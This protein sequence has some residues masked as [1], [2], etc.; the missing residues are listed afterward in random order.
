MEKRWSQDLS[1]LQ[2]LSPHCPVTLWMLM[3]SWAQFLEG[4]WSMES[5]NFISE[6]IHWRMYNL[7]T[8]LWG[9]GNRKW[10]GSCWR[11]S[12][13]GAWPW[14]LDLIPSPSPSW[15]SPCLLPGV[16]EVSRFPPLHSF[17]M[18]IQPHHQTMKLA[19]QDLEPPELQAKINLSSLIFLRYFVTATQNWLNTKTSLLLL[20]F[21]VKVR[22]K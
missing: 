2:L 19:D 18:R 6:L 17:A 14:R 21:W 11:E 8:F 9:I 12:I 7:M 16:H 3:W 22:I 1:R 13:M 20:M 5:C 10:M 15:I 4:N